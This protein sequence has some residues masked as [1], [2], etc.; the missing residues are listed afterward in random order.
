MCER[1]LQSIKQTL[2]SGEKIINSTVI[3]IDRNYWLVAE[4]TVSENKFLSTEM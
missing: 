4:N 2:L 1:N 3:N